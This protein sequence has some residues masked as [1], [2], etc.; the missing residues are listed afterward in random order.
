MNKYLVAAALF[1]ALSCAAFAADP[2]PKASIVIT[3]E[4]LRG[5]KAEVEINGKKVASVGPDDPY[6][7]TVNPGKVVITTKGGR[8]EIDAQPNKEYVFEIVMKGSTGGAIMFGLV[9]SS[10][11]AD[12]PITLQSTRDL[13]PPTG[14]APSALTLPTPQTAVKADQPAQQSAPTDSVTARKLR[15]LYELLKAGLINEQEYAEKRK[16]IL[17]AM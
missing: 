3:S 11:M 1:S 10:A 7:T 9:G 4:P 6:K 17:S 14:A 12:Y 8:A 15:E 13:V 2:T 16:A 5:N